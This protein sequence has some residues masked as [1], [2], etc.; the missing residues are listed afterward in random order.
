M[1]NNDRDEW[2]ALLAERLAESM[3][4]KCGVELSAPIN[5]CVSRPFFRYIHGHKLNKK[6]AGIFSLAYRQRWWSLSTHED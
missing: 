6:E 5:F 3:Y 2:V 4:H 1:D